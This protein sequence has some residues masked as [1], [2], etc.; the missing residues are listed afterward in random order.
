MNGIDYTAA[1]SVTGLSVA[2]GVTAIAAA[3]AT[4]T[5]SAVALGVAAIALAAISLASITAYFDSSSNSME[6]YFSNIVKHSTVTVSGAFQLA[7]QAIVSALVQGVAG[8]V[9][10]RVRRAIAGED[11]TVKMYS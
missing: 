10:T 2:A 1:A 6:E 4:T 3:S 7:T 11:V 8:A 5:V 9:E